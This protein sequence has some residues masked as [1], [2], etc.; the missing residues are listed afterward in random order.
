[1][2]NRSEVTP[3]DGSPGS[4]IMCSLWVSTWE[5]MPREVRKALICSTSPWS[6]V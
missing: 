1:M 4:S 5:R 3:T 2:L 6:T